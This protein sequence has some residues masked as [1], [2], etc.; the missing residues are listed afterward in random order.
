MFET[1]DMLF[2]M[3]RCCRLSITCIILSEYTGGYG[4]FDVAISASVSHL[5]IVYSARIHLHCFATSSAY[6]QLKHVCSQLAKLLP[7]ELYGSGLFL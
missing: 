5:G 7:L 6:T 1:R 4:G 2:W 3:N